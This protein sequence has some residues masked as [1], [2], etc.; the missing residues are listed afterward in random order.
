MIE[1]L[2]SDEL[3]RKVGGR[4]RLTALIQKR[5][6]E[7]LQGARPLVDPAGKTEMEI[8]IEEILQDK[9]AIDYEASGIAPPEKK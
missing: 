2:N 1:A 7:L 9:I 5:W 8:V 3:I 4:F 6:L